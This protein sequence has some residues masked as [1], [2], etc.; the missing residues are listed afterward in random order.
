VS[1]ADPDLPG[2]LVPVFRTADPNL[3]AILRTV[4]EA[5]GIDHVVQGAG[6]LGMFPLGPLATGITRNLLT[7]TIL[8]P[9]EWADEATEL[10][11]SHTA[12]HRDR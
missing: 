11:Q 4:L 3:L 12:Q 7:A 5:A 6:A 9:A 2:D 1:G 8:V 10:L